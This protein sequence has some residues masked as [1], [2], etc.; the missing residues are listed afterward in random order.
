M[1]TMI[2]RRAA[3]LGGAGLAAGSLALPAI[4]QN[5]PLAV[6]LAKSAAYLSWDLGLDDALNLAATYQGIVQNTAD[7]DEGVAA[8]MEGRAPVFKG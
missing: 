2:T 5:A 1:T 7:H 8:M 4:A 3:L 6:R